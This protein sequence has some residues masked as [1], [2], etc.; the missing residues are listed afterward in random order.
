MSAQT[1]LDRLGADIE[2]AEAENRRL[3]ALLARTAQEAQ[4]NYRRG[5]KAGYEAGR[6]G[7]DDDPG[8]ALTRRRAGRTREAA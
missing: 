5:Y 4:S 8:L 7:G 1:A 6:R 2:R 3:R